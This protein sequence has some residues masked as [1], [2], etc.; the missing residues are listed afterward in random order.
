M[1]GEWRGVRRVLSDD[2][3]GDRNRERQGDMLARVDVIEAGAED[4]QCPARAERAGVRR[5]IDTPGQTADDSDASSGEVR[6]ELR[7]CL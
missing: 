5:G 7:G 1:E 4:G 3:A 6:T 2:C